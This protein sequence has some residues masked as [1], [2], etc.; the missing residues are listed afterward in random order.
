MAGV[1]WSSGSRPASLARPPGES[2]DLPA[3]SPMNIR[4]RTWWPLLCAALAGCAQAM[5]LAWPWGVTES[6]WLVQRSGWLALVWPAPGQPW[7]LLQVV[8]MAVLVGL[9]RGAPTVRRAGGLGW[10]FGTAWLAGTFWWLFISMHTYG[11]LAAP[12]A[13]AAVLAL[14]GA[15]ALLVAGVSMLFRAFALDGQGNAAIV[16]NAVLW[17]ALWTLTE[18]ARGEWFTGFPWGAVGYA[19]VDSLAWAAPWVGVY[20]MG[21][22][23]AGLS[24]WLSG[25]VCL[26]ARCAAG[27]HP[28]QADADAASPSRRPGRLAVVLAVAGVPVLLAL[29][30]ALH[31]SLPDFTRPHGELPLV[32]LQGNI[33]QNEKFETGTGVPKALAWYGQRLGG[34][35]GEGVTLPAGALVVAPETALPLLPHQMGSAYWTDVLRPLSAGQHAVLTGLP[36]GN[37]TQ[38]YANAVWGITPAQ[39][40]AALASLT[41]GASVASLDGRYPPTEATTTDPF[42]RYEKHH[43]VPFGEFIPPLFRWFVDLM[44]I[45]LGDFNRGALGQAPLLWQGQRIAPNI[46]YED[47]FGEE[48]AQSFVREDGA[49]NVLVNLSNLAWFG[50]SVVLDQHLHISR[51]R[52]LELGRPM[53]RATNTGATV[54]ISHRGQVTHA[55][56]R[57]T[58]GALVAS[59]EGRSGLTPYTRWAA[60]WGLWP[61]WALALAVPGGLALRRRR[62]HGSPPTPAEPV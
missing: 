19:H 48:L 42:Y 4:L 51:L 5:A 7:P 8:A 41:Q 38:G 9:L 46:C 16:L 6:D 39:A 1:G 11:G 26:P 54:A 25:V 50:N 53:V 3:M 20:G 56:P 2:P 32:L 15:L 12:L 59:V 23:A 18:L 34:D 24:A 40:T 14:A 35:L 43:L 27:A 13:V 29:G 47:L 31:A 22:L 17:A 58:A 33:A 44:N 45:P 52:A 28:A 36:L 60:A 61:L 21:V 62:C 55:Q 57:H 10:V 30:P 49:P 37:F